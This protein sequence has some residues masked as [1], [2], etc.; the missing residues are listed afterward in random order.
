MQVSEMIKNTL[1]RPFE[2]IAKEPIILAFDLYS[3]IA[4][5]AFYLFFES[6]PIVFVE[7]YPFT[8]IELGVSY[9]GFAVGCFLAF[10]IL[11]LFQNFHLRKKFEDKSFVAEDIIL[12]LLLV[13]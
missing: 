10:F 8:L 11:A 4:Y 13:F 2:I 12:I 6:F 5:G 9:L 3:G 1:F 7:I